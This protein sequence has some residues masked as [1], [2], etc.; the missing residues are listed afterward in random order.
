MPGRDVTGHRHYLDHASTTPLR[1]EA[2]R[3]MADWLDVATTPDGVGD[4]GRVHT[5]GRRTRIAVETARESVAE[6]LGTDSSRVVFTSSATEAVNAAV[7]SA[8]AARPGAPLVSAAVEHSSVRETCR[9]AGPTLE[10]AVDVSGRV[11]LDQLAQWL[12]EEQPALVNCQFANHEVGTLQPVAEV[13]SLCRQA[14]VPVHCDA[15]AAAGHLPLSFTDLGVD[16]MSVSSHKL[17]GPPGVGALIVR[18]GLRLVPLLVGGSEERARRAGA[19]NVPGII[20]FGAACEALLAIAGDESRLARE[21]GAAMEHTRAAT[22]LATTVDGV[23]VAGDAAHR[24]PH[25]VCVSVGGVKGEAVLLS[26]DRSGV[27]VHSGSACS[28][29]VLEPSPVLA[30]MGVDPDS[31]LRVSVGWSTTDAD[32]SAFADAFPAA[33]SKLRAL[34]SPA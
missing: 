24:V 26:L 13:V 17:G 23:E 3:A 4:P 29:E 10:L 19:E 30:A 22:S 25:I 14:N 8:A 11:D 16:L 6:L 21:A 31:S 34:A 9:R 5:E 20:G 12:S 2:R 27:A 32:I 18:R 28:S 1:P 33:V 7:F 15:A